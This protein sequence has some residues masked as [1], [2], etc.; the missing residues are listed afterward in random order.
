MS[1]Y[2]EVMTREAL[3]G[4]IDKLALIDATA[5]KYVAD[6][7]FC[8]SVLKRI[9]HAG[10]GA[11]QQARAW[12]TFVEEL[13]YRREAVEVFR[14]PKLTMLDGGDCDDLTILCVAGLRSL[15]IP[16]IPEALCDKDGWAFHVRVLVGLPP[17]DPT[18]WAVVDPV[19]NSERQWAM[20]DVP[21]SSMPA[22][23]EEMPG[24]TPTTFST[25]KSS[26]GLT[27]L[28]MAGAL[29]LAGIRWLR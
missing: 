4:C 6:R 23:R 16:A 13:P 3:T 7:E 22:G 21:S 14:D 2:T 8:E 26:A 19:W 1:D 17:L 24:T 25:Q 20:V 28:L 27:G 29:A 10:S 15:D 11:D 9:S 12:C 18:V 5:S